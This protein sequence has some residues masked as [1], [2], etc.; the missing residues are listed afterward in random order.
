MPSKSPPHVSIVILNWNGKQD[1]LHCLPTLARIRYA[2][3]D[4]TVIDNA[5]TDG[6]VEAIR[7][8]HPDQRVLVMEKN[9]GF[10]GGNN[11]GMQ[12]ALERG[13][14]YVLLLNNDTELHPDML[15]ELV[16]V[17]ESDPRIGAVG[18][19]NIL[20]Q[21]HSLVWGA[22]GELRYD[23]DLV[24]LIGSRQ[25][26]GP[27]FTCV[28]DVDWV[29]GNGVM[30]SRAAIET[31]GGFDENFFGY[32]EDVDWCERARQSGFRIVYNGHAVIYH[33]GF[34]AAHPDSKMPFPVLYFLGRNSIIFA[35][36]HATLPQLVKFVT[37][38]FSGVAF[39]MVS[40]LWR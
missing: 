39:W 1:V 2:N 14:D 37:L 35:R 19:K 21:D 28:K 40:A 10:C 12:D 5:S 22:Y 36:K 33:K 32:H 26:D 38:F 15:D 9:L 8:A 13:A 34:G 20:M 27:L 6:S 31:V 23:R 25:P 7:A 18:T 17:A 3:W 16:R 4:A 11:R 24:R 30:K 29:I